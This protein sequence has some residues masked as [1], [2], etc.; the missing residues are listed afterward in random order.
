MERKKIENMVEYCG[1]AFQCRE[2]KYD[3][4]CDEI[5]DKVKLGTIPSRWSDKDIDYIL[6]EIN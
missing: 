6:D 5:E 4:L 3:K 1:N 2:C